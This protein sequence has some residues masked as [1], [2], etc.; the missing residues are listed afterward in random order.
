MVL[1]RY[2][3]E[4]QTLRLGRSPRLFLPGIDGRNR[5]P[6]SSANDIDV[7]GRPCWSDRAG[8]TTSGIGSY[9]REFPTP[10]Q[11]N[12]LQSGP[13]LLKL[14]VIGFR[15]RVLSGRRFWE[16]LEIYLVQMP[17][18][19]PDSQPKIRAIVDGYFATGVGDSP[20][21]LSAY[22][23]MEQQYYADLVRFTGI[24]FT[25]F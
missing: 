10:A 7:S 12:L 22:Q 4:Q 3:A 9:P 15:D 25:N 2:V 24:F 20:P 5:W 17:A 16:R 8:P 14:E 6:L 23:G 11:V 19:S 18:S 1:G 13:S 21:S